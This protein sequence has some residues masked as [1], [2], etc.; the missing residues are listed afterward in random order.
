MTKTNA[1]KILFLE[2]CKRMWQW[3]A[4][5]PDKWKSDYVDPD[6]E[7]VNDCWACQYEYERAGY[8][9]IG[10]RSSDNKKYLCAKYCILKRLWPDGCERGFS[11]FNDWKRSG[12]TRAYVRSLVARNIAMGCNTAIAAIK[13]NARIRKRRQVRAE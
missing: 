10:A 11:P 8:T 13:S 9:L 3:L 5:H 2:R 12:C 1:K 7:C 6:G 4:E